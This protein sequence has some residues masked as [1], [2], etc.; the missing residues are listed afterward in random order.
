ML[1]K[2]YIACIYAVDTY[3]QHEQQ[4]KERIL[5]TLTSLTFLIKSLLT[6]EVLMNQYLTHQMFG[7]LAMISTGCGCKMMVLYYQNN[8]SAFLVGK[9]AFRTQ[10]PFLAR[11]ELHIFKKESQLQPS[12]TAIAFFEPQWNI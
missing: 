5:N 3:K 4:M 12:T 2:C 7:G 9:H 6:M 1:N 11:N 10:A 8:R